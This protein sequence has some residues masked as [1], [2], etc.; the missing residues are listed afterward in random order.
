[1]PLPFNQNGMGSFRAL[2]KIGAQGA[3]YSFS[4]LALSRKTLFTGALEIVIF[5]RKGYNDPEK[6]EKCE[7][8]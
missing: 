3:V 4:A 2:P 5:S 1:M 8:A 7:R 6:Q